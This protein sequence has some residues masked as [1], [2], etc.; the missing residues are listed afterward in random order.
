M[1]ESTKR[2][3]IRRYFKKFPTNAV[4]AAIGIGLL[5]VVIGFAAKGLG[6]VAALGILL[7]IIGIVIAVTFSSGTPSD[8]EMSQFMVDDLRLLMERARKKLGMEA[9]EAISDPLVIGPGLLFANWDEAK[10]LNREHVAPFAMKVGG[11]GV[12]R[13]GSFECSVFFPTQKFL[14]TYYCVFDACEGQPFHERTEEFFYQDVVQVATRTE[15]RA[16]EFQG[17]KGESRSVRVQDM[18]MFRLTVSS[19]DSVEVHIRSDELKRRIFGDRK[20]A[21]IQLIATNHENAIQTIRKFLR[22]K[23]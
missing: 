18:E 17:E 13:M 20:A 15:D 12:L 2:S 5:C 9:E 10:G 1:D 8:S 21:Q 23:K 16:V 6:L 7:V 19:G 3:R 4:L 22:E 11:D 14:G